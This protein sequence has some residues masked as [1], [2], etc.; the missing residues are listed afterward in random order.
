MHLFQIGMFADVYFIYKLY[1]LTNCVRC[2][3]CYGSGVCDIIGHI[4]V[5]ALKIVGDPSKCVSKVVMER[6]TTGNNS[7]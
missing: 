5:I 4:N 2:V 7:A 6:L 3:R 1:S